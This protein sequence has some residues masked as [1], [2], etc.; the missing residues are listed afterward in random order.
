MEGPK[1]MTN[2]IFTQR[3]NY[4]CLSQRQRRQKGPPIWIERTCFRHVSLKVLKEN[5][6]LENDLKGPYWR[7]K[8]NAGLFDLWNKVCSSSGDVSAPIT[9]SDCTARNPRQ[10]QVQKQ[11]LRWTKMSF[12]GYYLTVW[13]YFRAKKKNYL[14]SNIRPA[15][16]N[17]VTMMCCVWERM[18]GASSNHCSLYEEV[19]VGQGYLVQMFLKQH[20]FRYLFISHLLPPLHFTWELLLQ[21]NPANKRNGLCTRALWSWR[22][23]KSY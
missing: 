22:N 13:G 3:H 6:S 10:A 23:S 4:L 11:T 12:Q 16:F 20:K 17:P 21:D 1:Q 7:R 14:F 5:K 19:A 15:I 8:L 18:C 2:G 9:A